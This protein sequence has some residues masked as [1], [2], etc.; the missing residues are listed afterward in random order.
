M[1]LRRLWLKFA[2]AIDNVTVLHEFLFPR[3]PKRSVNL[4]LSLPYSKTYVMNGFLLSIWYAHAFY[5]FKHV[6]IFFE[7]LFALL[8]KF[9]RN[10]IYN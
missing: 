9:K 1:L 4:S 3:T 2:M 5:E 6:F 10:F 7:V 8:S